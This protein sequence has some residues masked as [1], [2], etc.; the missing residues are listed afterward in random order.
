MG[1]SLEMHYLADG[2]DTR[3]GASG[4][5]CGHGVIRYPGDGLFQT[6]LHG[7]HTLLLNLPA[8]KG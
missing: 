4:A 3:V 6:T 8:V 2:V 7:A 1:M 5:D